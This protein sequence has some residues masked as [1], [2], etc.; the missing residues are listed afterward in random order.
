MDIRRKLKPLL[1]VVRVLA[2]LALTGASLARAE[3]IDLFLNNP[4]KATAR[5]NI[6]IV[7]DNAAS[8]NSVITQLPKNSGGTKKLDMLKDVLYVL[9]HPE[10]EEWF[11]ACQLDANDPADPQKRKPK[12][13]VTREEVEDTLDRVNIGLMLMNSGNDKGGYVRSHIRT[14]YWDHVSAV[15][16]RETLWNTVKNGIPSA[17]NAPYAKV[18]HEAHLYFSGKPA[19]VGFS[20]NAYDSAAR[21]GS[22]SNYVKVTTDACQAN[23]IIFLGNGGPDTGE[24]SD[25]RTLLNGLGGVLSSDPLSISPSNFQSNWTDEYA[26]T[27]NRMDLST[28]LEGKQSITTHTIAV[29]TESDNNFKTA[30]M[31][32]A[33]ELLKNAANYGGGDYVLAQ[34]GHEVLAALVRAVR[35]ML[36][37]NAVFAAVT[38][39]VSVNVRGTFLNQVYMG[40]FR[41]DVNARAHWP[42]NLKQYQIGINKDTGDP[43]LVDRNDKPA[44][45]LTNGFLNADITSFWTQSSN[46][47]AWGETLPAPS[48]A[49]D[50]SIVE[51]G[52]AAQRMR[53][54]FASTEGR[55]N[56]KLYTCNGS[57]TPGAALSSTL[58]ATSNSGIKSSL[59][60]TGTD[61][62]ALAADQDALIEWVRGTDNYADENQN[63]S[64]T[65][66]RAYIHGD[67]LHSRPAV[68]NYNREAGNRDILVYYGSNDGVFR[69]VKGGQDDSDG[70]EKWGMVLPEFLSKLDLLRKSD[71]GIGS[72]PTDFKKPYFADGPVSVYQNDVNKDGKLVAIDGDKA[73]LYVGMRRGGRF[74]YALDVSDP[75]TP[76]FMWKIDQNTTGFEKL[77]QTWSTIRPAT[78]KVQTNPV[79]IFGGG[80]DPTNEDPQPPV[81]GS[82]MGNAIYVVDAQNGTLIRTITHA[83]MG[84]IPADLTFLDRDGD[85]K[86]DRIYAVDTKANLWRVDVSDADKTKWALHKLASLGGTGGDARKFLNK[87]D[88]VVGKD[89]DAVLVGSGDREHPFVESVVDRFYMIKDTN[90]A[91]TGGLVCGSEPKVTCTHGD[92]TDVTS[93]AYQGG[94][95]PET[96]K[97][98]YMTFRSGEKLVSS[99]VTVFGNVIFGTNQRNSGTSANSCYNLGIARLYQ[100]NF[101]TGGAI[102]DVNADGVVNTSD[103]SEEVKGGG[104]LPSAVYSPIMIDGKRRDVVCV[105]PRCFRPGGQAFDT[106]RVRTY[107]YKK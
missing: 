68:V 75:D 11:P 101:L 47:W 14:M 31:T 84:A 67:L 4:V 100:I 30:S 81:A 96:S 42:G 82:A 79:L 13:C 29:Q 20:T 34:S 16:Y 54:V 24:D 102:S 65:D 40:Q 12:G 105:G 70:Y 6:L 78:L 98:W 74:L 37:Q 15:N 95:L 77:G 89:F 39:P 18:M 25:A 36:P 9:M 49:P 86:V 19:Y 72:G 35:K 64:K 76:K 97:G 2:V 27:L 38:L 8:N 1:A 41:P 93:N 107:W 69:A 85:G 50:G 43:R 106:R 87:P 80:Y 94:T 3:D 58:F 21:D 88:V 23:S 53:N 55:Q 73:W 92:L 83:D 104:Y 52:G 57:C 44:E 17:N 48:D 59:G 56:R 60:L 10:N 66:V 71:Q 45:D 32:S 33:R 7:L 22:S 62:T 51:K 46:Y 26:R 63:G 61:T 90:I 91:L 103:R 5:P 28:S 99:P